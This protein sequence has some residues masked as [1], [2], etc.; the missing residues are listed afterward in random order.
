MSDQIYGAQSNVLKELA[1][2]GPCVIVGRCA[3]AVLR[4]SIKIFVHAD[5]KQRIKRKLAM[6]TGVSPEKDGIPYPGSG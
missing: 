1:E 5:I 3:D 6:D 2:K 4:D